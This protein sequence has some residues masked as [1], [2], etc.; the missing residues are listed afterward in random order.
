MPFIS[1][2]ELIYQHIVATFYLLWS[3]FVQFLM[4]VGI[5]MYFY[6]LY[7]QFKSLNRSLGAFFENKGVEYVLTTFIYGPF[8]NFY[9]QFNIVYKN[10]TI[11]FVNDLTRYLLNVHFFQPL[12]FT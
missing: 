9:E 8:L 4:Q 2:G 12:L 5:Y 3:G 11:I 1:F 10:L 6:D 7:V